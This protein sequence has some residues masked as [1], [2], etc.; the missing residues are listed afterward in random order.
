MNKNLWISKTLLFIGL[1][2]V[3]GIFFS[4]VIWPGMNKKNDPKNYLPFSTLSA[5]PN[6]IAVSRLAAMEVPQPAPI[7]RIKAPKKT[8]HGIYLTA[9]SAGSEKKVNNILASIKKSEINAVVIDIK[10]YSG[11]LSYDSNIKMAN[12]LK[13]EQVKIKNIKA[14]IDKLHQAH[15]YVIAR[16]AVFQDPLLAD[17]KPEWA[18][19]SKAS[20]RAWRDRKGLAWLDTSNPEVWK[21]HVAIAKEAIGL[22]FDEIN[23]DYVRFPSDGAIS[24]MSFPY[25]GKQTKADA[26]RNFFAYFSQQLKDEPA[27]LS[28]DL[29]GLTTTVKNDM[30]IGQVIENA[31]PYFDYICPM[32]YPSHYPNGFLGFKNPADHPYEVIYKAIKSGDSRIKAVSDNRAV[33]R[34]WIQDFNMGAIYTASMIKQEL[35][36][37]ADAGGDGYLVWDPK[38]V[39]TWLAF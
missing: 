8:I 25:L 28:V 5:G 24:D 26:L 34:P 16:V 1:I 30:N 37:S 14:L 39:Y 21:Y 11:Y 36:A 29:F 13:L 12:D 31:A 7:M 27:Y 17:K 18:V 10:D 19:K 15:L 9:Y 2:I 23:L 22:G 32:V 35:K 33:L 4:L 6:T 20:G 3:I 38:N